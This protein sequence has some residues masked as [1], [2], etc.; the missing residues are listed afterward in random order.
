MT[1]RSPLGKP[2]AYPRQYSPESLHA[3]VRS[4]D[5]AALGIADDLP[6]HGCDL[7]NAWELTWL[8]SGGLPQVATAEIRVPVES[9]NIIESKSL[10]IYLNSFAMTN[11]SSIDAVAKAIAHD[12]GTCTGASVDVRLLEPSS[13]AGIKFESLPGDCLDSRNLRCDKW[14]VDA[15]L[16]QSATDDVINEQ[17]HSH[18]LRSLCP[19]TN[20]PD[21][22]SVAISYHGPR[23]DR[24]SLLRYIVS[25]RQ[26][27]A[28][29]ESC[30]ERM[31]LDIEERC[32]PDQLTVYARYQRRGGIDINPFRSNFEP[33]PPNGRLWR[34]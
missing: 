14:D 31:F 15:G 18:L 8:S 1:T 7:W 24:D 19:V 22:G 4:D 21:F 29:H 20:Q 23:I 6:F 32:E 34:Q 16:L 28:Y 26:H 27:H 9:P 17:I 10:K 33:D 5:R 3:I 30:V 12:L 25:Y 2:A 13:A 11:Y